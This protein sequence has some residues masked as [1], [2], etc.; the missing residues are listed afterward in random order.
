MT[1]CIKSYFPPHALLWRGVKSAPPSACLLKTTQNIC[2]TAKIFCRFPEKLVNICDTF[3]RKPRYCTPVMKLQ[4]GENPSCR[5]SEYPRHSV[6]PGVRRAKTDAADK[7]APIDFCVLLQLHH[8]SSLKE[9]Q[10]ICERPGTAKKGGESR[11][12]AIWFM[13]AGAP[14]LP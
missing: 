14:W 10:N 12:E 5:L 11:G 2:N 1:P 3:K 7:S 9:N 8:L 13:L 4:H 6:Y